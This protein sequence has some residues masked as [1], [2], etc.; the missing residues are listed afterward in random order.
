MSKLKIVFLS[1][2]GLIDVVLIMISIGYLIMGI[3]SPNSLGG[4]ELS[5]TGNYMLFA[6]Y[7]LLVLIITTIFL[8]FLIKWLKNK[9]NVN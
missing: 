8:I 2:L 6:V 4:R 1:T 9:K 5:F 7:A 3:K